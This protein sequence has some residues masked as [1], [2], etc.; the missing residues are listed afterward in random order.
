MKDKIQELFS[1]LEGET[2]I[3]VPNELLINGNKWMT[4]LK[5]YIPNA[6]GRIYK[7]RKLIQISRTSKNSPKTIFHEFGHLI[8]IE[9]GLPSNGI[10]GEIIAVN[11]GR[12][13]QQ[14]FQQLYSDRITN[15]WKE[16]KSEIMP[17][18]EQQ[19]NQLEKLKK[20]NKKLKSEI[21]NLRK[22]L[23]RKK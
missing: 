20:E 8:A 13:I 22:K 16:C 17:I 10:E 2:I 4:E 9:V 15:L 12:T 3:T 6:N 18:A 7:D 23:R 19:N 1:I 14:L 5:D 11:L 21:K